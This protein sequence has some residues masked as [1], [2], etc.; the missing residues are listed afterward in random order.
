MSTPFLATELDGEVVL[1]D[2]PEARLIQVDAWSR[3][4]WEACEGRTTEEV[5]A[6]L[7]APAKRVRE[8]LQALAGTGLVS[9]DQGRWLRAALR[10][11]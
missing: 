1:L 10:W 9:E 8:T 2:V 11:V 7:R 6:V 5:A 4:A 3:Q